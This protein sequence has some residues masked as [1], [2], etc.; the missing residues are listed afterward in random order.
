M[1]FLILPLTLALIGIEWLVHSP[2]ARRWSPGAIVA[3]LLA[4]T[5]GPAGAAIA[6]A[7]PIA[8]AR[9]HRPG[10][11]LPHIATSAT[12]AMVATGILALGPND[13]AV[14]AGVAAAAAVAI[15][16]GSVRVRGTCDAAVVLAGPF[17]G[18]VSAASIG[19]ASGIG[20]VAA[21]AIVGAVVAAVAETE[22]R[23]TANSRHPGSG[24]VLQ[25]TAVRKAASTITA[26]ATVHL[27]RMVEVTAI[28]SQELVAD[29]LSEIGTRT[30]PQGALHG[31]EETLVLLPD[32]GEGHLDVQRRAMKVAE[33]LRVPFRLGDLS[34]ALVP[35]VGI[36]FGE[37]EP[38]Q[39]IRRSNEA[40]ARARTTPGLMWVDRGERNG[41]AV[42]DLRLIANLTDALDRGGIDV[43]YQP[44]VERHGRTV[45]VEALARWEHPTRGAIP[46]DQFIE[47]AR[48]SGNILRLTRQVFDTTL[49]DLDR[50]HAQGHDIWAQVNIDA[51]LL[52]D[53][54]FFNFVAERIE[55]AAVPPSALVLEVTEAEALALDSERV[56]FELRELGLRIS[57]DDF[58]AGY[59]SLTRIRKMPIDQLKVDKAFVG[60]IAHD[61]Q[62]RI[63]LIATLRIA[64]ALGIQS[65][66]EGVETAAQAD[67]LRDF[68]VHLQQGY[69]HGR[70]VPAHAITRL[71]TDG[72]TAV[73]AESAPTPTMVL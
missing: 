59:S 1:P 18:Y 13:Q 64:G 29:L 71:L 33:A 47:L 10:V 36:V 25:T 6:V 38:S 26:A 31:T 55:R 69:L 62:S 70:P 39:M 23:R 53:P 37:A 16:S 48:R 72:Q 42:D 30:G 9:H 17:V 57:M 49:S 67:L 41:Q 7:V 54:G 24:L 43:A 21:M 66:C 40:A 15:L 32:N 27:G 19:T 4:A 45:A 8:F 35:A 58:G 60:D 61:E 28:L 46:P 22:R 56:L 51:S 65:V 14:L 11:A 34:V 3:A 52:R 12:A 73:P 63:I 44:I 68:G 5:A 50:W 2:T 20:E